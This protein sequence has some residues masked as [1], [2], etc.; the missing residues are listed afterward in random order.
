MS[1]G[2]EELT[3]RRWGAAAWVLNGPM[4]NKLKVINTESSFFFFFFPPILLR[5]NKAVFQNFEKHY[6][7]VVIICN[8]F[9][10]FFIIVAL[11]Q[12]YNKERGSS[13]SR[14]TRFDVEVLFNCL[15]ILFFFLSK[16]IS[17]CPSLLSFSWRS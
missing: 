8:F 15:I 7:I 16:V 4:D 3:T 14:Y 5:R 13:D 12:L 17:N 6:N 10:S 1:S 2:L 9:F 11:F